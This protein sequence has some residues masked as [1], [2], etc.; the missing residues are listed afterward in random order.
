MFF[1]E[2][3]ASLTIKHNISNIDPY[4]NM[5]IWPKDIIECR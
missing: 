3:A 4:I 2:G 1:D 5:N